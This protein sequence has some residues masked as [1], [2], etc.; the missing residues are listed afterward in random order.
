MVVITYDP[1]SLQKRRAETAAKNIPTT[2]TNVNA[3]INKIRASQVDPVGCPYDSSLKASDVPNVPYEELPLP[4]GIDSVA[5]F[6]VNTL[7]T[8]KDMMK[9]Q[10]DAN[11]YHKKKR[12]D[13]SWKTLT[14][15]RAMDDAA[16]A[17]TGIP[18]DIFGNTPPE[19]RTVWN[20]FTKNDRLRGLGI[21]F[22]MI[23]GSF[24][25]VDMFGSQ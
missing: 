4:R 13:S 24:A 8:S 17:L 14:I 3:A 5:N 11:A 20:I 12:E 15:R 19:S 6:D 22:V 18:N 21:I 1:K 25:I 9:L 2:L 7:V 16:E 23:A 10:N